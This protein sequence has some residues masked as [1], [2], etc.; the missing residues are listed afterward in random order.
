MKKRHRLARQRDFQ[1]VLGGVRLYSGRY[2]VGFA[3]KSESGRSRIGVAVSKSVKGAVH[4]NRAKRRLRE[5]AR[6][7]LLS[8]DSVLGREGIGYDVVLIA[9]PGVL[10]APPDALEAEATGFLSS[11]QRPPGGPRA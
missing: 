2:L 11:L 10:A 7:R 3:S 1:R 6:G 9:R 5:V 4:R 8:A